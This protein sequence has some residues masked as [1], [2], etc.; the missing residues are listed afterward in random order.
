MHSR[1][2]GLTAPLAFSLDYLFLFKDLVFFFF[3][4]INSKVIIIKETL[5]VIYNEP[6]ANINNPTILC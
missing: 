5:T 3:T 2:L 1:S 6:K 4:K